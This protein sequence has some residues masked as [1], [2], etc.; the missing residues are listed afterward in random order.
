[1]SRLA[2]A[3]RPRRRAESSRAQREMASQCK[4]IQ[5]G[6]GFQLENYSIQSVFEHSKQFENKIR[7][8]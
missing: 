2:I 5:K 4:T 3:G 7:Q 8:K 1:M 6:K